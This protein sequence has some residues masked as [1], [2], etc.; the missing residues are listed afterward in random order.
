MTH[1]RRDRKKLIEYL[2]IGKL[3]KSRAHLKDSEI[4]GYQP[5]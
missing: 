2:K 4:Q 3:M 5:A 1:L